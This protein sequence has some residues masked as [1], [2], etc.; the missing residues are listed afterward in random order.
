MRD[1][2][3]NI[4]MKYVF[5][6]CF[7][8]I[9][10]TSTTRVAACQ[11]TSGPALPKAASKLDNRWVFIGE[12]SSAL[13]KPGEPGTN[14]YFLDTK[15]VREKSGIITFWICEIFPEDS[16]TYKAGFQKRISRW[17]YD[18]NTEMVRMGSISTYT[19][20]EDAYS[21]NDKVGP[22]APIRPGSASEGVINSA[23]KYLQK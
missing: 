21:L 20:R 23:R 3:T 14:Y 6:L 1:I 15:T 19:D 10:I 12:T 22:W 11:T 8:I 4:R 9:C 18:S 17:E 16:F 7:S 5:T 13:F 2:N